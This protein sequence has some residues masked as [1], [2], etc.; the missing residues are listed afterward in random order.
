MRYSKPPLTYAD[1]A[2]RLLSR[3]LNADP[4]TLEKR[5]AAVSYYRLTGYLY[6]FRQ[7]GSDDF[8][9]G[10]SLDVVWRR[11]TFDRRFRLLIMDPIERVE[12][13]L[14]SQL[15]Y[16]HAHRHGA[17][18][19]E[20]AATMPG[21]TGQQHRGFLSQISAETK[22]SSEV[23]V[24]HFRSKYGS[25]HSRLPIWSAAE[26]MSLG[27]TLTL[28]RA[29]EPHIRSAVAARYRVAPGVLESWI[30]ALYAHGTPARITPGCGIACWA[31]APRFLADASI[32]NGTRRSLSA[33]T[34]SSPS[35]PCSS[36]S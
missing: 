15:V 6:P 25:H 23:F 31:C 19:Y 18:G 22:R 12:I 1:Q 29:V 11:Y 13:A 26:I 32:R 16:E 2:A 9:P 33:T 5:L 3:G 10:T 36:I 8:Q 17:F 14:R 20:T 27:A 7:P 21:L 35:S 4:A 34:V 24:Q 28:Y 30:R